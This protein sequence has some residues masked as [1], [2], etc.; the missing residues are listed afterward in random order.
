MKLLRLWLLWIVVLVLVLAV[1]L[2]GPLGF[3]GGGA[4]GPGG[5]DHEAKVPT[6]GDKALPDRGKATPNRA[7]A[8]PDRAKAGS[9][10]RLLGR[11]TAVEE[12]LASGQLGRAWNLLQAG[13]PAGMPAAVR[14]RWAAARN[15]AET[16]LAQALQK[17]VQN[18]SAA[19]ILA[20]HSLLVQLT[21][22]AS[23]TVALRLNALAGR[24]GWPPRRDLVRNAKPAAEV[25][26]AG[27]QLARHRRVR[28][29][30][31]GGVVDVSVWQ[32]TNQNVTVRMQDEDG[33]AFPV[34]DRAVVEPV[35]P[36]FEEA[37]EQV[38][39]CH[40]AGQGMAAWLWLCHCLGR[41]EA[42]QHSQEL[43]TLRLLLR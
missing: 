30:H 5:K 20:A 40:R 23:P 10:D 22:E 9:V 36:S 15:R 28:V 42:A 11:C 4:A 33:L 8:A 29:A 27:K 21:D 24:R 1:L 19:R 6:S 12:A 41:A 14:G 34:F 16:A 39:I 37:C 32:A 3:W 18:V 31:R 13:D 2:G 25:V 26:A 35:N 43:A 17:L 38:R 7:K